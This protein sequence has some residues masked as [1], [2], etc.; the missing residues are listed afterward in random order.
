MRKV[1]TMRSPLN[2]QRDQGI[3]PPEL[4]FESSVSR[5]IVG[6]SSPSAHLFTTVVV[7]ILEQNGKS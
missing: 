7:P 4:T 1:F 6:T 5:T 2:R 3:R